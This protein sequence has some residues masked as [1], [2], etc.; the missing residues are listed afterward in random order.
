M[1][2]VNR[3][4]AVLDSKL[5]WRAVHERL[6]GLRDVATRANI[7]EE[8]ACKAGRGTPV[9]LRTANRILAAF[10]DSHPAMKN[11]MIR[12]INW[13]K[14]GKSNGEGSLDSPNFSQLAD[15][16]LPPILTRQ[17][18]TVGIKVGPRTS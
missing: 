5:F 15:V 1:G 3:P 2:R 16:T 13:S 12:E 17:P 10:G 7:S 4:T 18:V 11:P 8:T 9:S 6:W 14:L